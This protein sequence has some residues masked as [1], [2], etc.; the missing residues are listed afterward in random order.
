MAGCTINGTVYCL[1]NDLCAE[2]V[3]VQQ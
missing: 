2:P 1:R 3:L